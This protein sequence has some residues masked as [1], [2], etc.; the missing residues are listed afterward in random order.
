MPIR[1]LATNKHT[2]HEKTDA[3]NGSAAFLAISGNGFL[4][5]RT[6]VENNS[7]FHAPLCVL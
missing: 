7:F 2:M 5:H 1:G 6:Q 4:T 3:M